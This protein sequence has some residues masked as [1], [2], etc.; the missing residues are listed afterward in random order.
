MGGRAV[1]ITGCSG[2]IG[3]VLCEEYTK[4]DYYVI[5]TD[6]RETE[7]SSY[8]AFI[9]CD[10]TDLARSEQT[11]ERFR[12][13]ILDLL[14]A[15]SVTLS[16]LINNAALQVTGSLQGLNTET[17]I[18][19]QLVNLVAPFVL[20]KLFAQEL[21]ASGGAVINIGSIHS[22]LTKPGFTAYAASKA[23]LSGLTRSLALDFGGEVTV[24]TICPAAF[25]TVMLREGFGEDTDAVSQLGSYHPAG[26]IG[27]PAEIAA[28]ALFLSSENARFVTG[29]DIAIDGG[30]GGR[31]HDPA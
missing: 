3:Q 20:T 19:T 24:N 11:Q 22:K 8:S 14:T 27:A 30:I 6:I 18:N 5:G 2:G 9:Y 10:L 28:L 23:G 29:A 13:R 1:L 7:G 26:R 17:F 4:S 16:V 21:R 31:L 15:N 25:D 12:G